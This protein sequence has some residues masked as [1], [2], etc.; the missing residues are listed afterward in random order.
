M[1]GISIVMAHILAAQEWVHQNQIEV[2]EGL[3]FTIWYIKAWA[4]AKIS[5]ESMSTKSLSVKSYA[6]VTTTMETTTLSLLQTEINTR[7][8]TKGD[9]MANWEAFLNYINNF[10]TESFQKVAKTSRQSCTAWCSMKIKIWHSLLG[11]GTSCSRLFC[12]HWIW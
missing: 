3:D 11:W 1:V 10:N 2:V 4:L 7:F 6:T 5:T 8:Q 9:K 12:W